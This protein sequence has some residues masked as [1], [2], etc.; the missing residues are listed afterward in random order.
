MNRPRTVRLPGFML[1][2]MLALIGGSE[3]LAKS[4]SAAPT[5]NRTANKSAAKQLRRVPVKNVAKDHTGKARKGK[6]SYYGREFYGKK[7]ANGRPMNPRNNGPASTTLPLGTKAK[8]TNLENGKSEVVEI[9]DRG[10]Y[11][12]GRIVDVSPAT[13]DKLGLK[14][15]GVAPVEVKPLVVP[16]KDEITRPVASSTDK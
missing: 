12:A 7:M 5:A 10:P 13:A 11:V 1:A 2:A 9:Q 3:A 14:K 16:P 8:V 6:A 4:G 15:D